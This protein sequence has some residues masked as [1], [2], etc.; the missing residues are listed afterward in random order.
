MGPQA[1]STMRS[2]PSLSFGSADRSGQANFLKRA[3]NS[4]GPASYKLDPAIGRQVLSTMRS[5]VSPSFGTG[6]QTHNPKIYISEEI[7]KSFYA[8]E[9]PGPTTSVQ[10]P[11]FYR[12]PL[13]RNR[14]APQWGF[15]QVSVTLR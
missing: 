2:T 11:G 15:S 8:R 4:P 3:A 1:L 6:P 5:S 12:Q 9:G 14:T 13:S 7:N 10:A